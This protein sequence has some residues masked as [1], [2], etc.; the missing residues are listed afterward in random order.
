MNSFT[1]VGLNEDESFT[2]N[3]RIEDKT[4]F[5]I[6]NTV[7]LIGWRYKE[8]KYD[9]FDLTLNDFLRLSLDD[10]TEMQKRAFELSKNLLEETWKKGIRQAVICDK[11]IIHETKNLDDI[12]NE[13]VEKLA[14]S[15]NK[16]CYVFSS[17]DLVEDCIWTGINDH[18]FYPTI[19]LHVGTEDSNESD[20]INTPCILADFD[21]GNPYY[22]V[23]DANKFT[24]PITT[25]SALEMR[26]GIHLERNYTYFQKK[27]KICVKDENGEIH[28]ITRNVRMVRDWNGCALLLASPNREA[29]VGRDVLRDLNVKLELD[30]SK[31]TTRI[32]GIPA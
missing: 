9:P 10:A 30:P 11:K 27:V 3:I 2:D 20:L 18:D 14:R 31:R 4:T 23:F 16:A 5:N 8:M 25:F 32:L 22:R 7:S 29:Y 26:Q 24:E 21:T 17:P 6:T 1:Y 19:C 28:S 12:P 15:K 13:F